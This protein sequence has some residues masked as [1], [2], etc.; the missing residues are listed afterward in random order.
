MGSSREHQLRTT[1][2]K[3]QRAPSACIRDDDVKGA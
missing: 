1:R 3:Y 2:V